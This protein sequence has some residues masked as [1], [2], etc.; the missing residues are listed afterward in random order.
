MSGVDKYAKKN[1]ESMLSR[2][3]GT[4]LHLSTSDLTLQ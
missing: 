3:C 1:K 2:M 4:I